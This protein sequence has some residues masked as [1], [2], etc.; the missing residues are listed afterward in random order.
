M[1]RL[2]PSWRRAPASDRP[3][4]DVTITA[5]ALRQTDRQSRLDVRLT[6]SMAQ[7]E[8]PRA[9]RPS[10]LRCAPS[11]P[12][13]PT[14]RTR[15]HRS[16]RTAILGWRGTI[17]LDGRS[18]PQR[19]AGRHDRPSSRTNQL[20]NCQGR[21]RQHRSSRGPG[22]RVTVCVGR[23]RLRPGHRGRASGCALGDEFGPVGVAG[24]SRHAVT[25]SSGSSVPVGEP[26]VDSRSI[27]R[28][29][30]S[31]RPATGRGSKVMG[32]EV[33]GLPRAAASAD[34]IHETASAIASR[35]WPRPSRRLTRRPPC[36]R[37]RTVRLARRGRDSGQSLG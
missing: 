20:T 27:L 29:A 1:D 19:S 14:G 32:V 21:D 33:W 37:D 24:R 5:P 25:S 28:R 2:H 22:R 34:A 9:E 36:V 10:P 4:A 8:V 7:D 12:S 18:W 26:C 11:S 15:Q 13:C 23:R 31:L 17:E 6:R 3:V 30:R 35:R 16:P